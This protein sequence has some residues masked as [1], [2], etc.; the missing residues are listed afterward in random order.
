M[1]G[2]TTRG[3]IKAYMAD[4]LRLP[5]ADGVFPTLVDDRVFVDRFGPIQED[6]LP[7]LMLYLS[8]ETCEV[9]DVTEDR[10]RPKVQIEIQVA[11][12]DAGNQIDLIADVIYDTFRNDEYLGGRE[13]GL[14]EWCRYS[15]GQIY[16]DDKRHFNGLCWVVEYDI[17][18]I[19]QTA[20]DFEFSDVQPFKTMQ[21]ETYFSE[22]NPQ[23]PIVVPPVGDTIDLAQ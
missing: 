9:L 2:R 11:G 21:V 23:P 1:H 4:K 12:D 10:R 17:H 20:P 3:A 13:E 15:R 14:V 22:G 18:Y 16:Y 8:E 6:E 19:D 7:A 5:N